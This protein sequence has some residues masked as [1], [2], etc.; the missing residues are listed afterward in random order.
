MKDRTIIIIA[1]RLDTIIDSDRV[2]V[3]SEGELKE[4]DSPFKLLV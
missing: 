2:L 1:H 4:F 3:M